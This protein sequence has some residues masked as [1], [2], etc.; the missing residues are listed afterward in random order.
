[1]SRH[2]YPF[3]EPPKE[4]GVQGFEAHIHRFQQDD[5]FVVKTLTRDKRITVNP[6]ISALSLEEQAHERQRSYQLMKKYL[7]SFVPDSSFLIGRQNI[8]SIR[9][10]RYNI[11]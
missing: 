7:G 5:R 10:N 1:M 3:K 11:S 6:E 2:E 8:L 4:M 9:L